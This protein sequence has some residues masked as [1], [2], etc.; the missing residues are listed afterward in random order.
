[1]DILIVTGVMTYVSIV[2][3]ICALLAA[4]LPN[5]YGISFFNPNV[6][7]EQYRVNWFGAYFMGIIISIICLPVS[8][9]YWI[10]KICTV[11]R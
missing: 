7:Y 1:M 2:T 11:G 3:I 9:F 6:L 5:G 10:Y 4:S 8:I